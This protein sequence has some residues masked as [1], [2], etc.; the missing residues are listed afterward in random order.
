MVF[1]RYPR[2]GQSK[3]WTRGLRSIRFPFLIFRKNLLYLLGFFYAATFTPPTAFPPNWTQSESYHASG[4]PIDSSSYP[5]SVSSQALKSSIQTNRIKPGSS[6]M[7]KSF[8]YKNMALAT[9]DI[10]RS[11]GQPRGQH[12]AVPDHADDPSLLGAMARPHSDWLGDAR[13]TSGFESDR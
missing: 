9:A 6:P 7:I 10:D 3:S 12:T 5:R 2:V 13:R 4:Y 1:A 11:V 8:E